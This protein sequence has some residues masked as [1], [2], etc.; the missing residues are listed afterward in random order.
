M[1]EDHQNNIKEPVILSMDVAAMFPSVDIAEVARAVDE[2]FVNSDLEI[3]ND[4]R[5]LGPVP[6][7]YFPERKTEGVRIETS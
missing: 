6:C 7:Y 2:E 4:E 1:S 5:E 3:E